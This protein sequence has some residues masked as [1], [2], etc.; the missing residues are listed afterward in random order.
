MEDNARQHEEGCGTL[1]SSTMTSLDTTPHPKCL[2]GTQP[3]LLMSRDTSADTAIQGMV[4]PGRARNHAKADY[5]T[6]PGHRRRRARLQPRRQESVD[7]P[8]PRGPDSSFPRSFKLIETGG[9]TVGSSRKSWPGWNPGRPIA[10]G[11]RVRGPPQRE[12]GRCRHSTDP[13]RSRQQLR[14]QAQSEPNHLPR[15]F[16]HELTPLCV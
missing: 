14:R 1:S 4:A 6:A 15:K 10:G 13:L 9:P 12:G 11:L 2:V 3:R 8:P 7:H 5:P 16:S